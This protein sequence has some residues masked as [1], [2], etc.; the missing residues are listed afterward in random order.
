V[1]VKVA[2]VRATGLEDVDPEA[3]ELEAL[4][5]EFQRAIRGERGDMGGKRAPEIFE[6]RI[7]GGQIGERRVGSV[8]A[9]A[10]RLAPAP[11]GRVLLGEAAAG[12]VE[13]GE[14]GGIAEAGLRRSGW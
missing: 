11:A 1:R 10:V 2:A 8:A 4:A 5:A 14:E 12:F 13:F 6:A 7:A 3:V 9:I